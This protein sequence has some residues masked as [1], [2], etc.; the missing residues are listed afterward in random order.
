[1]TALRAIMSV[2]L[3][4]IAAVVANFKNST[5][6]PYWDG[7]SEARTFLA[8]VMAPMPE[9]TSEMMG[10]RIMSSFTSLAYVCW[11]ISSIATLPIS[12]ALGL[13]VSSGVSRPCAV[14]GIVSGKLAMPNSTEHRSEDLELP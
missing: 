13:A 9:P 14:A 12:V 11:S 6:R 4:R 2:A 8:K 3:R 7:C 10:I 5:K 1:M